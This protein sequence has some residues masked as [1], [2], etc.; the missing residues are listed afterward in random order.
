MKLLSSLIL[1][2]FGV[3]SFLSNC[4]KSVILVC[5]FCVIVITL[6]KC[7]YE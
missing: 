3:A 2:S 4:G 1:L 6:V 5:H 7:S